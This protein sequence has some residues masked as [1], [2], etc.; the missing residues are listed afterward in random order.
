MNMDN[1]KQILRKKTPIWFMRQAGRYLPEYRKIRKKE[2]N[3]LDLCFNST[4]AAEISLQ[5]IK[6]F[7]FDFIILFSDILVIPFALGQKVEFKESIG[8]IL[9]KIEFSSDLD[10]SNRC[11]QIHKLDPIFKTIKILSKEKKDKQLIGFCGGPFTVLTYMLEGG[12]SKK[13]SIVKKKIKDEREDFKKLVNLITEVSILYLKEQIISGVDII[14]VFESWAGLLD[15]KDY[16]EFI[17]EPNKK[18]RESIKKSFPEI[19]I[20]FFPRQS[21]NEIFSF[22]NKV[23]PDVLSLDK[24]ILTNIYNIA[25]EKNIILQGNLDPNILLNGG[26]ELED[27]VKKIMLQFSQNDHIFNLSHG[28]LPTTPIDN[29][30][31]TL[32]IIKDFDEAK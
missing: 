6:R 14:K 28:I 8:P 4:L 26:K 15:E 11:E 22:I 30:K 25:K 31:K 12:T 18:I 29:V 3:F 17:I 19:P 5:P 27:E 16:E 2:K 23:K 10:L 7:N 24:K 21:K 9:N 13:H 1:L 20:I 32:D